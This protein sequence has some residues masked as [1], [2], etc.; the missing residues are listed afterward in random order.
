MIDVKSGVRCRYCRKELYEP[1]MLRNSGW[2]LRKDPSSVHFCNDTC[3]HLFN[4]HGK[5][6]IIR[7]DYVMRNTGQEAMLNA[8]KM[9]AR[10]PNGKRKT[11]AEQEEE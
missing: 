8:M 3:K 11:D 2:P 7:D 10:N 6:T 4:E 1:E 5:K 9:F